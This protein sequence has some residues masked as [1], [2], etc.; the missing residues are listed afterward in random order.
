MD[1]VSTFK[2]TAVIVDD[3]AMMRSLLRVILR[4][5]GWAVTGEAANGEQ[6]I[7]Q[8]KSQRPDVVCLDVM[9]PGMS[10]LAVLAV[11]RREVPAS[12]V[13]MITSDAS[14]NTVR[15]ALGNGASGF[16]VKPFNA[17]RV[18]DA[19]EQAMKQEKAG[20]EDAAG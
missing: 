11:L 13:V 9:M 12:R 17:K 5:E 10:G 1:S 20:E 2:G 18:T 4:T 3:D 16:I 8:C 15:E 6:A 19:L 14:M 7:E